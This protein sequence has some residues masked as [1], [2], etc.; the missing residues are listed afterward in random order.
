ME[1]E[2]LKLKDSVF[3]SEFRSFF[4]KIIKKEI[5]NIKRYQNFCIA[6]IF[7]SVLLYILIITWLLYNYKNVIVIMISFFLLWMTYHITSY[8]YSYMYK[9][10]IK[11]IKLKLLTKIFS[12]F[13]TVC[14][15]SKRKI[16]ELEEYIRGTEI[17]FYNSYIVCDDYFII[18]Y[19]DIDISI[20][21]LIRMRKD[22]NDVGPH[23]ILITFPLKKIQNKKFKL[24]VENNRVIRLWTDKVNLED[25]EFKKHFDVYSNDQIE[26]RSILTPAVM[27][28]LIKIDNKYKTG[29]SIEKGNINIVISST[30]DWF[31][32]PLFKQPENFS[33]YKNIIMDLIS[34]VSI[35]DSLKLIK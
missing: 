12:F 15:C 32:I 19:N 13:G 18:K 2:Y 11:K 30:K 25:S 24:I 10:F 3:S 28:R 33:H 4:R 21:D 22:C 17:L 5:G 6:F 1:K 29:F 20:A 34:F 16:A 7:I 9:Y 23:S 31:E 26:A 14:I 8:L 27:S 35:I